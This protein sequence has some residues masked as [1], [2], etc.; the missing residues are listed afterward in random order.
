MGGNLSG[1]P[2][3]FI[4]IMKYIKLF[5]QFI[6]ESGNSVEN[7]VPF[8]QDQ[9]GPTVNW[10][11]KN[12]FSQ[13][14]LVGI[15]DDAAVIGSAGKKLPEATS[16]DIDIAV[17]ADKIAGALGTSLDKAVFELDKKLKSMG[18]STRLAPAFNQVSF[19]API[20]G[21]Y[22]NGVG[23]VDF[24]LTHDLEWS[25]FMYHS[26]DFRKAE[27]MYKGAYRNLLLM[28]TIGNCFR[29]ITKT[30]DKGET[31]EYQAYVIRLNQGVVQVRK[32]F[33]GKKGLLKNASLLREFDKE[34]TRVPQEIVNLLFNGGH[35]VSE[36]M[37]YESLRGLLESN[38][39]KYPEKRRDIL[40]DFQKK[41]E[42]AKLPL[43]SD[44]G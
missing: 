25:R 23:Q 14:G 20:G 8:Q 18:Y 6:L 24:M 41:L 7:A 12:I 4:V 43:P 36:I 3:F 19:G 27:S 28:A 37:T 17:S 44:M 5:E 29:E 15:D 10:I 9:V 26:P 11:A 16:G 32:S 31:A 22:K 40:A 42:D 35:K 21:D 30:T 33:E 2:F 1:F 13:I 38:D 39:F 34:I